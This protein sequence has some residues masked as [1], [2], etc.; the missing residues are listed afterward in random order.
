MFAGTQHGTGVL[1]TEEDGFGE[2][3]MPAGQSLCLHVCSKAVHLVFVQLTLLSVSHTDW[4][5]P[6]LQQ[7]S[8]TADKKVCSALS[9]LR[10]PAASGI[11]KRHRAAQD[12]Q[13][14]SRFFYPVDPHNVAELCF[15]SCHSIQNISQSISEASKAWL[16]IGT[17]SSGLNAAIHSSAGVVQYPL[18]LPAYKSS[19]IGLVSSQP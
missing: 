11:R 6:M 18:L 10:L 14:F 2:L 19:S 4:D 15:C 1:A 5:K 3:F 13:P 12:K 7:K 17:A 16:L 8:R 9:H